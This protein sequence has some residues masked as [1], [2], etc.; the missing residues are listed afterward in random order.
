[1]KTVLY[2]GKPAKANDRPDLAG[3]RPEQEKIGSF[4]P[5]TS[6]FRPS[7]VEMPVWMNSAG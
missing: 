7:I 4:C 5:R 1:M 6:V 2:D 3:G